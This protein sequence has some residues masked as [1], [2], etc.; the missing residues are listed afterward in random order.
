MGSSSFFPGFI[1]PGP[2]P[3]H[4]W[5]SP[6]IVS[7]SVTGKQIRQTVRRLY[8]RRAGFP[9]YLHSREISPIRMRSLTMKKFLSR[10]TFFMATLVLLGITASSAYAD[11][12]VLVVVDQLH[13]DGVG[14][15]TVLSLQS[16]G[17]SST[18]SGGVKWNGN[19]DQIFGNATR[20]G[21][22]NTVTLADLGV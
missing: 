15:R 12:I 21:T 3:I 7:F 1:M 10:L 11:G 14:L 20:G 13:P 9:Q 5:N 6:P 19:K 8:D 2:I 18:E 4:F 22:N 17:S 16:P